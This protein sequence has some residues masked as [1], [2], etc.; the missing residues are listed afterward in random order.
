MQYLCCMELWAHWIPLVP[1]HWMPLISQA[2]QAIVVP[3][4]CYWFSPVMGTGSSSLLASSCL[5]YL[6]HCLSLALVTD[7][8]SDEHIHAMAETFKTNPSSCFFTNLVSQGALTSP[9]MS[10]YL[11][12]AHTLWH[13]HNLK[14]LSSNVEITGLKSEQDVI[15]CTLTQISSMLSTSGLKAGAQA[16]DQSN[17]ECSG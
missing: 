15:S 3:V 9:L 16:F 12:L 1:S 10:T 13:C 4:P 5:I 11:S 14:H 8:L 7:V 2:S 6:T 17:A